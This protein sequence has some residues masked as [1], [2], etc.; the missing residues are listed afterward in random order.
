MPQNGNNGKGEE[1]PRI[2]L[3]SVAERVGLSPGTVSAVLNNSPAARHIPQQT[4]NR[5]LAAA[6]ELNY[7]PNFF[8]RSLRNKR[9]YMIGVIANDLGAGYGSLVIAGIEKYTRDK[10]YFFLTGAHHHD[11]DL[12]ED[13]V[14]LLSQRGVEG[15][16]TLDL[17]LQG[18]LALPTVAVSGHSLVDGV[19]NIV[20]DHKRAVFLAL[21]HLAELGHRNVAFLRGHPASSDA[22]DRWNAI[23]E[24]GPQLGIEVRPELTVQITSQESSPELG[25]PYAKELL[26]RDEPFTA[27][28]AYNDISAIGAIRA[29]QEAGLRVPEDISLV[30]FDDIQE[31]AYHRPSLTTVRQPLMRMGEIAA[32]T[33]L[34]K[35]EGRQDFPGEIA[36]EPELMVR[37]STVAPAA[38]RR[39]SWSEPAVVNSRRK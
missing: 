33:L 32:E 35:I 25:Y 26:E 17:N 19:T 8:A 23:C 10:E 11:P 9:S 22:V 37:E 27:L 31:A 30:G 6:R 3:K 5:V 18:P 29:F 16:I 2:T 24:F 4:R 20:L 39:S 21:Q 12:F 13:Y 28:F 14:S 36:V 7:R 15:F 34:Q 1:P 38:D